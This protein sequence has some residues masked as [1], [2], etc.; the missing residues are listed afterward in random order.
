M[1]EQRVEYKGYE[2]VNMKRGLWV[3]GLI[4]DDNGYC[5]DYTE[6]SDSLR[7]AKLDIT[8]YLNQPK[9]KIEEI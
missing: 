3:W 5:Y 7:K 9:P 6:A 8:W 4:E 1:I 2:I